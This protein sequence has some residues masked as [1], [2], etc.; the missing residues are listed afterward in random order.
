V[1]NKDLSQLDSGV[2]I[3][4]NRAFKSPCPPASNG[5]PP[6]LPHGET[7]VTQA[8]H[9]GLIIDQFPSFPSFPFSARE[10][11][12]FQDYLGPSATP[13]LKRVRN[14]ATISTTLMAMYLKMKDFL[15]HIFVAQLLI[16]FTIIE[17]N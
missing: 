8:Q 13:G 7:W 6:Y 3:G 4:K 12:R 15:V 2:F 11:N 16:Y 10:F 5:E 17:T 9:D 14:F 1:N